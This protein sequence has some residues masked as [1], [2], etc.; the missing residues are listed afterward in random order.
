METDNEELVAN[1]VAG[2]ATLGQTEDITQ[3]RQVHY[4]HRANREIC[5][6]VANAILTTEDD[7]QALARMSAKGGE[8][9]QVVVEMINLL[10]Q[11]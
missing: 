10:R 3:L 2:L 6:G 7:D 4:R 1:G 5:M 8:A 9:A 11:L